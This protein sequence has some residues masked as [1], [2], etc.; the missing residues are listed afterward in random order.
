MHKRSHKVMSLLL[1][2]PYCRNP[3]YLRLSLSYCVI[4]SE[5]YPQQVALNENFAGGYSAQ[6]LAVAIVV[7]LAVASAV[8][9]L[10]GYRLSKWKLAQKALRRGRCSS[11]SASDYE[12]HL[13]ARRL[14]RQDSLGTT[15][16]A[17]MI[18]DHVYGSSPRMDAVSLVLTLPPGSVSAGSGVTTPIKT[19]KNLVTT[20]NN[21]T[22]PKDY[23]VKKVYLWWLLSVFWRRA[24]RDR[25]S[26]NSGSYLFPVYECFSS[27]I[28]CFFSFFDN[29]FCFIWTVSFR[30][31]TFFCTLHSTSEQMRSQ[32]LRVMICVHIWCSCY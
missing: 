9:F 8:G 31:L 29:I 28:S 19:E 25:P 4:I 26:H 23:K 17:K 30:Q 3:M 2:Y 7:T 14:T 10:V 12:S 21:G 27:R 20:L 16:N 32:K 22:L 5:G 11:S 6:S 15:A 1:K 13:F 24:G 18:S